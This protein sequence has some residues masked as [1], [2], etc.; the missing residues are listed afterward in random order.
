MDTDSQLAALTASKNFAITSAPVNMKS[1]NKGEVLVAYP[2]DEN[3]LV[4]DALPP[5]EFTKKY[6]PLT[7]A[8]IDHVLILMKDQNG[9]HAPSVLFDKTIPNGLDFNKKLRLASDKLREYG[10]PV[11]FKPERVPQG[12]WEKDGKT[13]PVYKLE[14]ENQS[15]TTA[16]GLRARQVEYVN[17]TSTGSLAPDVFLHDGSRGILVFR[18]KDDGLNSIEDMKQGYG[19]MNASLKS[20]GNFYHDEHYIN[21]R[22]S[23]WNTAEHRFKGYLKEGRIRNLDDVMVGYGD[24]MLHSAKIVL[25]HQRDSLPARKLLYGPSELNK[26]IPIL[27]KDKMGNTFIP[28]EEASVSSPKDLAKI[29]AD[30]NMYTGKWAETEVKGGKTVL[31][32]KAKNEMFDRYRNSSN[33]ML[34][35]NG[36]LVPSGHAAI[37]A[38][39]EEFNKSYPPE[40]QYVA[41]VGPNGGRNGSLRNVASLTR[42]KMPPL[43]VADLAAL[44]RQEV[45]SNFAREMPAAPAKPERFMEVDSNSAERQVTVKQEPADEN[46]SSTDNHETGRWPSG[47]SL[48][49]EQP[50]ISFRNTTAADIAQEHAAEWAQ[51]PTDPR[52]DMLDNRSSKSNDMGSSR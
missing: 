9:N 2:R 33:V 21:S 41:T 42:E 13:L 37:Q 22:Q 26:D 50:N 23:E 40:L 1:G 11:A 39:G 44:S 32:S 46:E 18:H 45:P 38:R 19:F 20:T 49:P 3:P 4:W 7:K 31:T 15:F 12:T 51:K 24:G 35:Y 10:V 36:T 6:G 14:G 47:I 27:V 8:D 48:A 17:P 5:N 34:A 30:L 29:I 43:A 28:I 16:G 25:E 52:N